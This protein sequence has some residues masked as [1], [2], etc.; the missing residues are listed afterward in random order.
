M[1]GTFIGVWAETSREIWQLLFK[2]PL[3]EKGEVLSEDI[4]CE[5]YRALTPALETRP[6]IENLAEIIDDPTQ[7]RFAFENVAVS[8]LASES[9][10]IGFFESVHSV[11]EE[12]ENPG[13][14]RLTNRYFTLLGAFIE[15]FSLRYDLR[16]PCIICPTLPG[17]VTSLIQHIRSSCRADAHLAKLN[18]EFEEA[19]RD[20]KHGRTEGRIKTYL[21]KQYNLTEGL[22]NARIGTSGETLGRC[23]NQA[24]WPHQ[25]LKVAAGNVYGFRSDYPGLGHAGNSHAVLRDIDDRELI[26]VSCMLLGV[27]PYV[28]STVNLVDLYGDQAP[29]VTCDRGDASSRPEEPARSLLERFCAWI[30]SAWQRIVSV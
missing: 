8:D 3:D 28:D 18:H 26:G 17:L 27:V 1:R 14:D 9:A 7:S 22:A 24:S 25:T 16:R 5:L 2:E 13:D 12:F 23:C 20:L 30:K 21:T 10:L 6:S 19:L 15:K 29:N 11:L 4:F